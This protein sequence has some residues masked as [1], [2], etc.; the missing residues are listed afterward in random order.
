MP[1]IGKKRKGRYHNLLKND[2]MDKKRALDKLRGIS[3]IL[4]EIEKALDIKLISD[5]GND[6]SN[7][8]VY[9]FSAYFNSFTREQVSILR[10]LF[11]VK[12][13]KSHDAD[14]RKYTETL[15]IEWTNGEL[16]DNSYPYV[17]TY[18][19]VFNMDL[20]DTCKV[21][22]EEVYE[23]VEDSK[24]YKIISNGSTPQGEQLTTISRVDKDVIFQDG[25][26]KR[27]RKVAKIKCEEPSMIRAY[28]N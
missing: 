15:K 1:T 23:E 18:D 3:D 28:D 24:E 21:V 9:N 22:I 16:V 2:L 20:P 12:V 10:K 4:S 17:F 27:K 13:H 6:K 26:F 19:L 14:S 7:V 25:K 11:K 8:S 5:W